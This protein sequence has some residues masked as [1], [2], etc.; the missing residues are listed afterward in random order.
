MR[1]LALG[2]ALTVL[3]AAAPWALAQP[4]PA[5]SNPAP[6]PLVPASAEQGPAW[7]TLKPA[8]REALKPLER[9]WSGIDAQRKQKWIEIAERFPAM[10]VQDK[11]RMQAR[12]VEW[13]KLT[14]SER[15]QVRLNYQEA[16]QVPAGNRQASW[17]AY[18][19]LPPE[20]RRELADRAT[21]TAA[22]VGAKPG[23]GASGPGPRTN[24]TA[25]LTRPDKLVREGAQPK[26]NTVPAAVAPVP[27]KPVAP[28]VV[29]AQPGATTTLITKPPAP[30]AH[31]QNGM[32]KIA[33]TPEF[34][35]KKTLLPQAGALGTPARAGA[36]APAASRP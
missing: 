36:A 13:A 28:T 12:M 30:P 25:A 19:A 18:Q 11:A 10:P 22:A 8:Q 5:A 26:L 2:V 33:T 20:Q 1:S 24:Q 31:Q 34:V 27:A 29:Q 14:P 4:K 15:G 23:A 7:A 9:D 35:D 16:K 6:R 32:P 3:G 21:P 17:E